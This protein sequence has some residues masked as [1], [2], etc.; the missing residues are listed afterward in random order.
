[1]SVCAKPP[2]PVPLPTR[3]EPA[4]RAGAP[5][6]RNVFVL[7]T[8][9]AYLPRGHVKTKGG[10]DQRIGPD[11]GLLLELGYQ[12]WLTDRI[13]LDSSF[14]VRSLHLLVNPVTDELDPLNYSLVGLTVGARYSHPIIAGRGIFLGAGADVGVYRARVLEAGEGGAPATHRLLWVPGTRV[15]AS[16][17]AFVSRR[18]Q[19]GVE[20]RYAWIA[21]LR[22]V[23]K[24]RADYSGAELA[25]TL[26]FCWGS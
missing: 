24:G 9:G 15:K 12:R 3:F 13:A 11:E 5:K 7:G 6:G 16:L 25:F 19:L 21:H 10:A 26:G 17:S 22:R 20:G 2:S 18:V 4:P 1:M 23:V 14:Q 8:G